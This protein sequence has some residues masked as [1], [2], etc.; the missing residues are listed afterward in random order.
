MF[1][2]RLLLTLLLPL[3][4]AAFALIFWRQSE[5]LLSQVLPADARAPAF[6]SANNHAFL[7]EADGK[8]SYRISND[9]QT[10]RENNKTVAMSRVRMVAYDQTDGQPSWRLRADAGERLPQLLTLNGDVR[11][12]QVGP[13]AELGRFYGDNLRLNL[14]TRISSSDQFVRMLRGDESIEASHGASFDHNR[15]RLQ[16][17]DSASVFKT[18]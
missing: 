5:Q 15:S 7:Y 10:Q 11:A 12:R 3:S 17:H 9:E 4:L 6:F 18:H 2:S 16:L 8:L 1:N 13:G 14:D